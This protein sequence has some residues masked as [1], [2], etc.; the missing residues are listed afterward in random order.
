MNLNNIVKLAEQYKIIPTKDTITEQLMPQGWDQEA[1]DTPYPRTVL[2][3][4]HEN[5]TFLMM[6][7]LQK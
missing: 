2:L 5:F 1:A 7:F 6:H 3:V 4:F